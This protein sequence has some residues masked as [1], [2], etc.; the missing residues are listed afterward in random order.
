MRVFTP[1]EKKVV[2]LILKY[3]DEQLTNCLYN[4]L[5]DIDS[6]FGL[7]TDFYLNFDKKDTVGFFVYEDIFKQMDGNNRAMNEYFSKIILTIASLIDFIEYLL[8]R[9]T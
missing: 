9:N 2:Q 8:K 4:I 6:V 5:F 7:R 1:M 3:H